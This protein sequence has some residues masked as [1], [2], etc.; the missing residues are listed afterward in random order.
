[1]RRGDEDDAWKVFTINDGHAGVINRH[2]RDRCSDSLQCGEC[3]PI[4]WA[5]DPRSIARIDHHFGDQRDS[6]LCRRHDD[7][8]V[9]HCLDAAMLGK[10]LQQ[11]LLQCR[12]VV[13][14]VWA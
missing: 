11:R 6:G 14:A 3:T 4:S 1:M 13:R 8:L 10:V 5:F 7:D 12:M 2:A 9:R